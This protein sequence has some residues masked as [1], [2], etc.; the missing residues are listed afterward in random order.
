MTRYERLIQQFLEIR[1]NVS[2]RKKPELKQKIFTQDP[3]YE[4]VNWWSLRITIEDAIGEHVLGRWAIEFHDRGGYRTGFVF[5]H[6]TNNKYWTEVPISDIG[7]TRNFCKFLRRE[8]R[9][10]WQ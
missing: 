7:F 9:R 4:S 5:K 8:A 1:N 6:T 2:E 3:L 10:L